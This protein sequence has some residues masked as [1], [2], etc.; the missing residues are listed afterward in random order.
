[1]KK[2]HVGS[3]FP[4]HLYEMKQDPQ[5]AASYEEHMEKSKM[6]MLLKEIRKR[7]SITQTEL[8]RRAG[9]MQ[10]VIARIETGNSAT[11][12]RLDLFRRILKAIGYDI[13]LCAE[14]NGARV[15]IAF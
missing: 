7:E 14:K 4:D 3:S 13:E 1:M 11:L 2:K 6:A 12:P 15:R 9:V 10:S 5:F 8:A